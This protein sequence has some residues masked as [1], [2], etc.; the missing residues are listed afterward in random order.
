MRLSRYGLSALA[1]A[2]AIGGSTANAQERLDPPPP[3]AADTSLGMVDY[4]LALLTP[5]STIVPLSTYGGRTLLIN[6][7]ASWC[8]PCIR[9]MPS[10]DALRRRIDGSNIEILMI[11]VDDE[12]DD[13]RAFTEKYEVESPVFLRAWN[14]QEPPFRSALLP[15]TYVVSKKGHVV[16]EHK[17]AADWDSDGVASDLQELARE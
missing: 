15:R 11:S 8:A 2:L 4:D 14:R 12:L 1:I 10:I 9:E 3:I 17:G 6:F 16:Y 5:D 13:I 7:W